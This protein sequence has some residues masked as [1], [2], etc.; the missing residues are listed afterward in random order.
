M[1]PRIRV[2]TKSKELE[3]KR[4]LIKPLLTKNKLSTSLEEGSASS[5]K[6]N[7]SNANIVP[8]VKI[9]SYDYVSNRKSKL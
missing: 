5:I 1:M 3:N 2:T 8:N 4:N 9:D 7:K 6:P